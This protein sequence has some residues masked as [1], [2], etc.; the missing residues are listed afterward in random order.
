[1]TDLDVVKWIYIIFVV[2]AAAVLFARGLA[3][4]VEWP[5]WWMRF[6]GLAAAVVGLI[7]VW[8]NL[9]FGLTWK[10]FLIAGAVYALYIWID[11]KGEKVDEEREAEQ[12]KKLLR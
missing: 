6:V 9:G 1:M 5:P 10:V 8:K 7:M 4:W 12:Q 11:L 2:S 3:H